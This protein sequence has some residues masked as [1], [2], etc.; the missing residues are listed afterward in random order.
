MNLYEAEIQDKD[1][2][3][4]LYQME[5]EKVVNLWQTKLQA[6]EGS[7]ALQLA[8]FILFI[9]LGRPDHDPRL[10]T[11]LLPDLN[12]P[13]TAACITKMKIY[14]H[15]RGTLIGKL[16]ARHWLKDYQGISD[17]KLFAGYYAHTWTNHEIAFQYTF[18]LFLRAEIT[19]APSKSRYLWTH[20]FITTLNGF[21][22]IGLQLV[23]EG[24]TESTK[25]PDLEIRKLWLNEGLDLKANCLFHAGKAQEAMTAHDEADAIFQSP[26]PFPFAWIFNH[27]MKLRAAQELNSLEEFEKSN[28]I[29]KRLLNEN[30]DSRF[31]LRLHSYKAVFYALEGNFEKAFYSLGVADSFSAKTP[32]PLEHFYHLKQKSRVYL[33]LGLFHE[34]MKMILESNQGLRKTA[35][36]GLHHLESIEQNLIV[37]IVSEMRLP[38]SKVMRK[39]NRAELRKYLSQLKHLSKHCRHR[40]Q[41]AKILEQLVQLSLQEDE[42][43]FFEVLQLHEKNLGII[44]KELI[45]ALLAD[46]NRYSTDQQ[47]R[48]SLERASGNLERLEAITTFLQSMRAIHQ[49][50]PIEICKTVAD[51]LQKVARGSTASFG[52]LNECAWIFDGK[53]HQ[54]STNIKATEKENKLYFS[55]EFQFDSEKYIV[56]TCT[57][58]TD[59]LLSPD[60]NR[61]LILLRQITRMHWQNLIEKGLQVQKEKSLALQNQARMVAHDIRSP[62]TAL[63]IA[64]QDLS[65]LTED[66]KE[67]IL[68]GVERLEGIANDLLDQTRKQTKIFQTNTIHIKHLV[69]EIVAEKSLIWPAIHNNLHID[70]DE[71]LRLS[72]EKHEFQR[73][74]NNVITNSIEATNLKNGQI[75]ISAFLENQS[76]NIEIRDSGKGIPADV[77]EKIGK[78]EIS[79]DK[80]GGNGLGLKNIYQFTEKYGGVSIIESK[81]GHGTRT[82]LSFPNHQKTFGI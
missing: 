11:L 27:S 73:I 62:L 20:G 77:L 50:D 43:Q 44:A 71:D 55:I 18:P 68:A 16:L 1:L 36:K 30:Y 60:T 67:L 79:Y 6:I 9:R 76:T 38:M 58:M 45:A 3:I 74:L 47:V 8:F 56:W 39:K 80:P 82:V 34:S 69:E 28:T 7:E 40:L 5:Y 52:S 24:L 4:N 13:Q 65:E 17:I 29:L 59:L 22:D 81:P 19:N 78:E 48:G 2:T 63:K 26:R 57:N 31:A 51:Y 61:S 53:Q 32:S 66:R 25:I 49:L 75:S 54:L 46:H 70:I 21:I 33:V 72:V 10:K 41:R 35:S 64:T 12:L 37:R 23:E 15:V 14:M 42:K